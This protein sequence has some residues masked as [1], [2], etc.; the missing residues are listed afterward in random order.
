MF[1]FGWGSVKGSERKRL[2]P[3]PLGQGYAEIGEFGAFS[4]PNYGM[5]Q[6]LED[7][8]FRRSSKLVDFRRRDEGEKEGERAL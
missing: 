3:L 1:G 2:T 6:F 7:L 8:R 4:F 5:E